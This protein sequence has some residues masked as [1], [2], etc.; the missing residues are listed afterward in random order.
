[1]RGDRVDYDPYA[2]SRFTVAVGAIDNLDQRSLYSEPGASLLVVSQSDRDLNTSSDPAIWT[3]TAPAG[4][5]SSFGGT[6]AACP[7]VAGAVALMLDANPA[8]TWRDVQ[9]VL[10]RSARICSPA[11]TGWSANGAGRLVNHEFGFGAVDAGAAAAL[12]AGWVN[13]DPVIELTSGALDVGGPIPNNS[14]PGLTRA[15]TV[16]ENIAVEHVEV[17][18]NVAHT[19]VGDLRV[20]LT[21]P[22]GTQSVFA[23][24]RDDATDNYT[25]FVFTSVRC[26]D[27]H[28]AGAWTLTISDERPGDAG[29]WSNWRLN[30]YG[31]ELFCPA[32]YNHDHIANS[33]DLFDFL[34]KFF[35]GSADFNQDGVTNSADFFAFC[36][37]FFAGC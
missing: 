1:V 21:S 18:L 28:S 31:T 26:W 5:V 2:S 13:V 34:T 23:Q 17:V 24:P 10:L 11:N 4:Y 33:Q 3:T 27:E 14:T 25:N 22:S 15:F 9:H 36:H 35:M 29:T 8:L 7:L 16:Q 32:D 12:A 6:S 20:T 30:V 37:A 19:F